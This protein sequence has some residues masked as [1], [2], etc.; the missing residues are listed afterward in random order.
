LLP[1]LPNFRDLDAWSQEFPH[2][3][4]VPSEV[5]LLD[6]L[7]AEPYLQE[8]LGNPMSKHQLRGDLLTTGGRTRLLF[9]AAEL[10]RMIG[11][12][13]SNQIPMQGRLRH[14]N[15]YQPAKSE[16]LVAP[17]LRPVGNVTSQPEGAGH[18]ADYRVE[19]GSGV[20]V[21][22]V[23]RLCTSRHEERAAMDRTL[24][25]MT[26]SGPVFTRAETIANARVDARRLYPRVRHAAKQLRQS[27]AKA[28]RRFG[29]HLSEVPGI[30]FLDLDG[31]PY[32]L[33]NRGTIAGWMELPWAR[34]IDLVLFFDFGCRNGAWGAIAEP[35]F[36]RSDHALSTLDRALPICTR[37]HFHV[38]NLP[39]GPCE[40]PLPL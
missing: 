18:G 35:I 25:D 9:L 14:S 2:R 10:L 3:K 11:S 13:G 6:R 37:G 39:G 26:R 30:L 29:R 33:N 38:G 17:I 32:L 24:A 1:S 19:H 21:A 5:A 40:F 7:F 27:A 12:A 20:L 23:K 8:I 34:S 36:S 28:A 16:L 4:S 15:L 22:E 31:D